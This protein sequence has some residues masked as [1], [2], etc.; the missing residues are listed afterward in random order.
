MAVKNRDV[1]LKFDFAQDE[2]DTGF[3]AVTGICKCGRPW[4]YRMSGIVKEM[5]VPCP[6]CSV[7]IVV[8]S[9]G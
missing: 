2:P 5:T 9:V 7:M 1:Q 6:G 3:T 4:E 8:K